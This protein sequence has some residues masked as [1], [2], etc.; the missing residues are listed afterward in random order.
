MKKAED[1]GAIIVRLYEMEGQDTTARVKFDASLVAPNA[2][3]VETDVMEQPLK[4]S[5]AKMA[6]GTLSVKV[7]AFSTVTV[8][9]R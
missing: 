8:K 3:A 4:T 9:L 2:K 7:P 5:S 6:K 1:S